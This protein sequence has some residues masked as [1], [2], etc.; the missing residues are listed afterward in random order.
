[1]YAGL[2]GAGHVTTVDVAVPAIEAANSNWSLNG[3]EASKHEGRAEDAFVFLEAA[4]KARW[5]GVA[6][7]GSEE[8]GR[9]LHDSLTSPMRRSRRQRWDVVVCDPPSFCPNQKSV[10][11]GR[12]AYQRLF[13]LAAQCTLPGGLLALASCSSHMPASLF[14]EV[15]EEAVAGNARRTGRTLSIQGQPCDHPFPLTCEELRYL[16]F[17]LYQID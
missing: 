10:E 14:Y 3:L 6:A 8:E 11:K 1:M 4:I 15:C 5:E 16:K 9:G 13:G 2:G 7:A 12:A 17:N